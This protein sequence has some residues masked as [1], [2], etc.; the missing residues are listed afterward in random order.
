MKATDITDKGSLINVKASIRFFIISFIVL[1]ISNLKYCFSF[2]E[3]SVTILLMFFVIFGVSF[4]LFAIFEVY[5]KGNLR[6][7]NYLGILSVVCLLTVFSGNFISGYQADLSKQ[8]AEKIID[9]LNNY[10]NANQHYPDNLNILV[11]EYLESVPNSSMG[12]FDEP[13]RYDVWHDGRYEFSFP[14]YGGGRYT[15]G[16]FSNG[17]WILDE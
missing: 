4:F 13:Y 11:P 8:K 5:F 16:G 2:F 9:A 7:S 15:S 12:W 6:I 3:N 14:S 1:N 10:K 17:N